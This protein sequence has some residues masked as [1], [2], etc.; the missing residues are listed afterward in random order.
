M[1]QG[2]AP[3][4]FSIALH[5]PHFLVQF[6]VVGLQV[7]DLCPKLGD[8]LELGAQFLAIDQSATSGSCE[9]FVRFTSSSS[10]LR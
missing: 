5:V 1:C 7:F 4:L 3:G 6:E 9:S 10:A 8:N 2:P